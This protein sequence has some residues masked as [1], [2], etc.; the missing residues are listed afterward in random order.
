MLQ[1][2]P[3]KSER[4]RAYVISTR[5]DAV[6]CTCFAAEGAWQRSMFEMHPRKPMICTPRKHR[7]PRYEVEGLVGSTARG[8]SSPLQRMGVRSRSRHFRLREKA[9][10]L[11]TDKLGALPACREGSAKLRYLLRETVFGSS[12]STI[13]EE[14]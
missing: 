2:R 6:R 13:P 9:R 7:A 11:R 8:G 12:P 4:F 5:F 10:K 1:E 14:R 3:E